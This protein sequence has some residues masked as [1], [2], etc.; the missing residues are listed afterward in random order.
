MVFCNS[1]SFNHWAPVWQSRPAHRTKS[2]WGANATE[3][4]NL[5]DFVIIPL[6]NCTKGEEQGGF[7]KETSYM[8]FSLWSRWGQTVQHCNTTATEAHRRRRG[9]SAKTATESLGCV[10]SKC[11]APN[12]S[13]LMEEVCLEESTECSPAKCTW[14][15]LHTQTHPHV[16]MRGWRGGVA[17]ALHMERPLCYAQCD[18]IQ[19][20]H[21]LT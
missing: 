8:R 3:Q 21:A 17:Q 12:K 16:L 9:K 14:L 15:A 18:D 19:Q 10:P 6:S 20:H 2:R 4:K 11:Q 5:A 7:A 13:A 1:Q